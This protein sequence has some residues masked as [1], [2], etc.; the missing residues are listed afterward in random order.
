MNA[1]SSVTLWLAEARR[2]PLE[3]M[4]LAVGLRGCGT[5]VGQLCS[6]GG[7]FFSLTLFSCC[8]QE[9]AWRGTEAIG[10]LPVLFV[11]EVY[12]NKAWW[13]GILFCVCEGA[14]HLQ[15]EVPSGLRT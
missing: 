6:A 4:Q 1:K 14:T 7:F 13:M 8:S 3:G 11:P 9:S 5:A 10:L 2:W 15:W 12:T